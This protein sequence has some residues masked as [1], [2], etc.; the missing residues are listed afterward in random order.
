MRSDLPSTHVIAARGKIVTKSAVNVTRKV[1]AMPCSVGICTRLCVRAGQAS[2]VLYNRLLVA[3]NVGMGRVCTVATM[4][5][6][7]RAKQAQACKTATCLRISDIFT[8]LF[9]YLL[10]HSI[11]Y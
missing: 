7:T 3:S 9:R 2:V 11:T 10:I 4:A 5:S 6:E 8:Y 1:T